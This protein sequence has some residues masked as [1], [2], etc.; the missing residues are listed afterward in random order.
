[1]EF[2]SDDEMKKL[3]SGGT[4]HSDF[5]SDADMG[6]L[7]ST[8]KSSKKE[9]AL[10]GA[11]QGASLGFADEIA[12]GA[13]ALYD[14]ATTDKELSDLKPLYK[15]HRDESRSS[16]KKAKED[17]PGSYTAGEVG[18]GIAST[19]IP[20]L[21]AGK[22][23]AGAAKAAAK[24]GALAGFGSSDKEDAVD[25]AIDSAIGATVGGVAG[26]GLAKAGDLVSKKAIPYVKGKINSTGEK[27]KG[28]AEFLAAHDL[29]LERK[30][31]ARLGDAKTKEIGRFALDNKLNSFKDS[32]K[33]TMDKVSA[34]KDKGGKMMGEVYDAIDEKELST[35]NPR[36]VAEKVDDKIGDFWRSDLNKSEAN[37]YENTIESILSRGNGDLPIK[38]AQILKKELSKT[39]NFNKPKNLEVTPKEQMA[40]DAYGVI[41]SEI[42]SVVASSTPKLNNPELASKFQQGK[43]I[44]GNAKGASNL[45]QN[46]MDKEG[47]KLFG[48]TNTITGAGSMTYGA[49]TGDW[50]GALIGAAGVKGLEKYGAKAGARILDKVSQKLLQA[51]KYQSLQ[52]SNPQ[53]FKVLVNDISRRVIGDNQLPAAAVKENEINREPAQEPKQPSA[54]IKIDPSKL[55]GEEKWSANGFNKL[56][57]MDSSLEKEIMNSPKAK[58]LLIQASDLKPGSKAMDNILM[59]LKKMK[60]ANKS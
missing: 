50:D 43:E 14:V 3:E 13:S 5:I 52:K 26:A 19:V 12:G 55:K 59:Q 49:A 25:L 34:L 60:G 44:Y 39:A 7:E 23:I 15:L 33:Q 24:I 41:S 31:K 47:N 53:A 30:T 28:T 48:L 40:R 11:A 9:S 22:G 16:F 10:R 4:R 1:M 54:P 21:N 35:F 36:E 32:T 8:I 18:G 37:Q 38:E 57:E 29:G 58:Q 20:G 51:P 6:N 2:I 17:N 56:L 42:D 27:L 45:V 46:K